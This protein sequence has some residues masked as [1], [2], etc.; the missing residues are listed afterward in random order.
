MEPI[1]LEIC[2]FSV[3]AALKA[4]AAGADRIELCT[5]PAEGGTTPS[6]GTMQK[7]CEL[8]HIPVF[9]IIR[10]RG[11]DFYYSAEEFD[12]MAEDIVS[13]KHLGCKG[14]A[15]GI[16]NKDETIDTER[17]SFLVKLAHPMQVTFI[18]AFDLVPDPMAALRD[19]I[20][21]G[22]KRVLTSGQALKAENAVALLKELTLAARHRIIVMPGSGITPDNLETLIKETGAPEY[23]SSARTVLRDATAEKFGFGNIYSCNT[24]HIE[25]MRAIANRY[26]TVAI[27]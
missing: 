5:N 8:L 26:A 22:C 11:G 19:L 20:E 1:K 3:D 15:L 14:V 23:H 7:A 18:R 4:Q 27:T 17:T 21:I 9:P 25:Q 13:A 12:M 6:Y 10:P 24:H 16:L 2:A